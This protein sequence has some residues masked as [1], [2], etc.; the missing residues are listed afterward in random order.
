[1]NL[2]FLP[3]FKNYIHNIYSEYCY[4]YY[5]AYLFV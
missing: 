5:Y 4:N 3:L 1:M 2:R